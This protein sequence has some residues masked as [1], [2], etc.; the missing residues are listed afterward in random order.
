MSALF[1]NAGSNVG[2]KS[3][4]GTATSRMNSDKTFCGFQLQLVYVPFSFQTPVRGQVWDFL[5]CSTVIIIF[6][7][8]REDI[9]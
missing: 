6:V 7:T 5:K 1:M 9:Y 2:Y 8:E 3:M 4:V